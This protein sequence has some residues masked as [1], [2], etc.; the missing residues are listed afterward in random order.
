MPVFSLNPQQ[1]EAVDQIEGSL[2]ILA[3]AGTGKTRVI[4]QR[5]ENMLRHGIAPDSILAVTFTNK[6]AREMRE[7]VAAMSGASPENLPTVATF[8]SFCNSVLRRNAAHL[9]F[10]NSFTLATD[11]YQKGLLRE[12]SVELH[13]DGSGVDPYTWLSRISM[14]KA[15]MHSP[16]DMAAADAIP[17][18]QKVAAIYKRYQERMKRMNMMD[19]DDI[20]SMTHLLWEKNP[21]IL[22]KYRRR[23]RYI[24]VDEYQDT[25]RIQL[26]LIVQLAG[27]NGNV[28]A[29]GDDDQSIY[30]WRG[31]DQRNIID[32]TSFFPKSKIIRLE[33]N[34][35]STNT[36][37]K[38]ANGLIAHNKTRHVKNLWS[39]Q[40]EG[41]IIDG[42]RCEDEKDE[43]SFIANAIYNSAMRG[44][45][46][47]DR[48]VDWRR[49]AILYRTGGQSRH[50]E[51][52][53]RKVHVPFVIVGSTSFYQRK[54]VLDLLTMLELAVNQTNDMAFQRVVNVPPRGVGDATLDKFAALRDSTHS[55]YLNLIDNSEI[56]S[57]L[58]RDTAAELSGFKR[59]IV[60]CGRNASEE[61]PILPRIKGL[62]DRIGY[63][64]KLIQM[65]K[66]RSDALARRDNVLEFL[67]SIAD[68]DR[69]K[70]NRGTLQDFLTEISLQDACDRK[71]KDKNVSDNAVSL[72]TIH[73]SKGLEFPV[74]FLVG[75]EQGL[76]PHQMAMDEGSLEEERRLCYVAITRAKE[77]LF[78]T[79]AN[80]RH[81]MNLLTVKKL[82]MFLDELPEELVKYTTS[83]EY[84]KKDAVGTQSG[85][86]YLAQIRAMFDNTKK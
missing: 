64:D 79:Y 20:L 69:S 83:A 23:F 60:E 25:N 59:A 10:T 75:L 70:L 14:A 16:D 58:S 19:F 53:L 77:K 82:S 73:A 40:G 4:V 24:M 84:N 35:R 45:S 85:I 62:I 12:I 49:F 81:V 78:L 33:Q 31:A 28:C 46:L 76:F 3:G 71:E 56:A 38:A 50:F 13:L 30:G 57:K 63:L 61:G 54:E 5:I 6:A 66:P 8:H 34:Y 43:A 55:H 27:P 42:I 1:Q 48:N 32:F 26:N 44:H 15:N 72:M 17:D 51:E 68:Y 21:D 41:E 7:R 2:L 11:G 80:K 22:E 74:V 9:G 18:A 65:Y 36:I 39:K 86:D 67:N 37:L 29:V 52:A 47:T